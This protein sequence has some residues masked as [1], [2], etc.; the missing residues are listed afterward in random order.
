MPIH[1][2]QLRRFDERELERVADDA[3]SLLD[4][5][6]EHGEQASPEQRAVLATHVN[7]L[8]AAASRAAGTLR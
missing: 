2:T 6:A 8:L 5:V 1:E 7:A 4:A 3:V